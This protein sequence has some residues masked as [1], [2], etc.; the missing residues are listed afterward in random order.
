MNKIVYIVGNQLVDEDA[1]PLKLAPLL[2]TEF[3][4]IEFKEFDPTENLP[5]DTDELI[6]IDTVRGIKEPHV[7]T[8]IDQ[9]VNQATYSLHDFDLGWQLKLYKK[10]RMIDKVK[11]IGVPENGKLKETFMKI[12]GLL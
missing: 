9:F 6:M 5:E 10:L 1:L 2:R 12:K 3:P 11:I 7:F 4:E 8:D